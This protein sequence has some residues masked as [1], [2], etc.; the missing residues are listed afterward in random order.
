MQVNSQ[1]TADLASCFNVD[2][3]VNKVEVEFK[4]KMPDFIKTR[5]T[6]SIWNIARPELS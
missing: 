5:G 1:V 3:D 2:I 4:F 6:Y